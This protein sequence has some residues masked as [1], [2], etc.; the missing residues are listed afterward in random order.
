MSVATIA[1]GGALS[2]AMIASLVA[3]SLVASSPVTSPP[4]RP[5]AF[6]Q[7]RLTNGLR[8]IIAEDHT[9]PVFSIA[10]IYNVGSRDERPSRT[11]LAHLFEHLMFKGSAR[12][13]PGEHFTL[14][15]QNG[16]T[17]NATT[18]KDRT[19][20]HETLPAHQLDLALFL[21]ADRMESLAITQAHFDNQRSAVK[22]E[23][24]VR[25]D[26]QPYGRTEE[27]LERLAYDGS[28]YAHS[29]I[30]SMDDLDAASLADAASFFN[31]YYGPNNAVIAIV[32]DV[33]AASCAAKVQRYFAP[34][35]SRPS[36]PPV[37]IAMTPRTAE[38]RDQLVDRLAPL[39]RLDLAFTT[40]PA[41]T[42]DEP[43]LRVLS[44][45]LG[46]GRSSRLYARL[47]RLESLAT[48]VTT[49]IVSRRG[50]GLL[51]VTATVTSGQ[52]TPA[53]EA[54]IDEELAR[55]TTEPVMPWELQKARASARMGIVSDLQSSASRAILLAQY[56]LFHDDPGAIDARAERIDGV[57]A[58]DVLRVART[59]LVPAR[60]SV[61][62]TSKAPG[63]ARSVRW[64]SGQR[65]AMMP[66][67][68][69]LVAALIILAI[70]GS[71]TVLM[72]AQPTASQPP[73]PA[74]AAVILK[75]LAPVSDASVRVRLP[76]P[77]AFDLPNG[78]HVMVMEDRRA[79][80]VS[81]TLVMPGAG[82][83][84]DPPGH[85]GL[86]MFTAAM[87]REGTTTRGSEDIARTLEILSAS[88][89]VTAVM[90]APEA[91]ITGVCLTE[92][93]DAVIDLLAD[94]L[95]HPSFPDDELRRYK[96]RTRASL[97]E[98]RSQGHILAQELFLR[99]LNGTHP[100][101]RHLPA[102]DALERTTSAQLAAF[103]RARYIPDGAALIV[104]GDMSAA[105]VRTRIGAKLQRWRKTGSPPPVVRDP[106][107]R[108]GGGIQLVARPRSVQT[109]LV[110]G[111]TAIPRSSPDFY[112]WQVMNQIV[113][114]APLGR[115]F[116]H[117]REQKGY[118]YGVFSTLAAARYRGYWSTT[119]NVRSEVTG[120]AL[121]DLLAEIARLRDEPVPAEELRRHQRAMVASF[122]LTL[123]SP[124]QLLGY[125]L[126]QWVYRLPA[127]YWDRYPARIMAV[128]AADVQRVAR[129]YLAPSALHVVAVGDPPRIREDLS[130][131]GPVEMYDAEG[132]R[133]P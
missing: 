70:S 103:H 75:G 41:M 39:D 95:I 42:P 116:V 110:V 96:Q 55:L 114:A 88:L 50:P 21:E 78:L 26:N 60:R 28:A 118:T 6:T 49:A 5:V 4:P 20:Y 10:V 8:A 113:G 133:L 72:R 122:A 27:T 33:D 80:Q 107:P 58:D 3:S 112:A 77:A 32:G 64:R 7:L 111:A 65:K 100:S 102:D 115:L 14:V 47:V 94:V 61:V 67:W 63:V 51:R 36:P 76:R 48:S 109:S 9:A 132:R 126:T 117:L 30:G 89:D 125:Q 99:R 16:G 25:F 24:R 13:G 86:A 106:E 121:R 45:I 130:R 62:I 15:F 104:A 87:M 131:V 40:S 90:S 123:E 19:L 108:P 82:G 18:D 127:N 2:I 92:H 93:V 124:R 37:E 22:E 129:T 12:V 35:P 119:T 52:S 17:M 59:Y 53:V 43:A 85:E 66:R 98:Q 54:A 74:E 38:R 91:S 120:P 23:R 69:V 68:R 34:L 44:T 83:Y 128:T 101:A 56:A 84:F 29:V 11:G 31:A 97:L 105:D 1:R 71:A 81:F 79:P 73:A 57:T 46:G